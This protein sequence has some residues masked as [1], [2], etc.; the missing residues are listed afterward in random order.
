LRFTN[1]EALKDLES[2]MFKK[3]ALPAMLAALALAGC[4]GRERVGVNVAAAGSDYYDGYYDGYYGPFV[5][6]YWGGD[7]AFWYQDGGHAW[8]R[9]E[10]AHF[11]HD[12]GGAGFNHVHGTG[13]HRDH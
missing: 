10:G 2:G 4:A 5:D 9:D 11:R 8:H 12:A 1:G 6:G 3:L 13:V 7:G